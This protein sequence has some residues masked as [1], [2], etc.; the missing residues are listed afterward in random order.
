[1]VCETLLLTL[2]EERRPRLFENRVLSR[3]FGPKRDVLTGEWRKHNK[4][5]NDKYSSSS[6]VRVTKSRR[7]RWAGHVARM[8]GRGVHRVSVGKYEGKGQLGRPRHR[9][10]DNIKTSFRM[11]G[12]GCVVL[13]QDRDRWWA[14]LNAVMNRLVP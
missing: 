6:I 10:E 4:E 14:F 1:M 3:I 7:K 5:L 13:A 11:W 2:R 9:W 12:M 8:V